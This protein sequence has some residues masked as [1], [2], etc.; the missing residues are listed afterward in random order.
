LSS[1]DRILAAESPSELSNL[2]GGAV[3][4]VD[5]QASN[6]IGNI[7]NHCINGI[8]STDAYA[9]LGPAAEEGP[10]QYN[11]PK[12]KLSGGRRREGN[13]NRVTDDRFYLVVQFNFTFD[14]KEYHVN[15]LIFSNYHLD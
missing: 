14:K 2:V 13:P 8:K 6:K 4:S 1:V 3:L 5:K 10:L 9:V 15:L 12:L 7:S 11:F